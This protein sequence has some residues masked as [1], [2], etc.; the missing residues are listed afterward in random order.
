MKITDIKK[1]GP[2]NR[3]CL[4]GLISW[5]AAGEGFSGDWP[6][7][8]GPN[9]DSVSTDRITRQWSGSVTNPVWLVHLT[10][11]IT[12][13]TV[14]GGRV[15]TQV[16]SDLDGDGFPHKEY[17]V[18]LD[19]TNG[20]V[21]W[22]TEVED[23]PLP[24]YLYPNRGVGDDDGPRST[25]TVDGGSVYVL[26]SYLK[27]HRLNASNGA[28]IWS[29]NLVAGFG[30]SVIAWQSAASP[31]VDNGLVFVNGNAGSQRVMAFRT[32][33]GTLAWRTHNEGMTHSTP[34]LA[35]I[36]GVRQLVFATQRGLLSLDPATGTQL[37]RTN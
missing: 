19:A 35:T 23:R 32:S 16:A 37:W 3:W 13:L 11:G 31:V 27:L 30:G 12:S 6:K 33:N 1:R 21:L 9:Q 26:S 7:L 22:S 10:N 20:D 2:G 28:V 25:P 24:Q 29:T 36:E 34:V 5:L 4:V 17:C 15:F 8:H 18:A 14:S